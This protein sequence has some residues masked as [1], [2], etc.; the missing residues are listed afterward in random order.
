MTLLSTVN[1]ATDGRFTPGNSGYRLRKQARDRIRDAL[2]AEYSFSTATAQVLLGVIVGHLFDAQRARKQVDRVRA[3]NAA[4]RLLR[5]IPK[6][7]RE[8]FPCL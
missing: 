1:R 7:E 4:A 5:G 2:T 8:D 3:A 6:R